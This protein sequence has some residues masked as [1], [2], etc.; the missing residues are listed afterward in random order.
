MEMSLREGQFYESF[1]C[2]QSK[3]REELKGTGRTY[4]INAKNKRQL[5]L[6]CPDKNCSFHIGA[7][8]SKKNDKKSQGKYPIKVTSVILEHSCSGEVKR[9]Q[10][11]YLKDLL[12]D[13]VKKVIKDLAKHNQV[14]RLKLGKLIHHKTGKRLTDS[15]LVR[16]LPKRKKKSCGAAQD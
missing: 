12:D 11:Y 1:Q 14:S 7:R 10:N 6:T 2:V 13:Q 3:V 5:Y 15:Q 16:L 8:Y 4:K 9:K